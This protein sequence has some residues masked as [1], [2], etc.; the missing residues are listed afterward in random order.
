MA[1]RFDDIIRHNISKKNIYVVSINVQGFIY[2]NNIKK[3]VSLGTRMYKTRGNPINSN[4][5][6]GNGELFV[7]LQASHPKTTI[8][9][10]I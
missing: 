8:P 2:A 6:C 1:I 4:V 10:P 5:F 3:N 7:V 9:L